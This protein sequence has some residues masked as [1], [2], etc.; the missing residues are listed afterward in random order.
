MEQIAWLGTT[1]GLYETH[2]YNCQDTIWDADNELPSADIKSIAR[3]SQN[4]LWAGTVGG[5]SKYDGS[6][7]ETFTTANS[8]LPANQVN[9]IYVDSG[10]TLWLAIEGEGLIQFDGTNWTLQEQLFPGKS[11]YKV[12]DMTRDSADALWIAHNGGVI[13]IAG[14]DTTFY[15]GENSGLPEE[16]RML[17]IAV[18]SLN[19]KWFGTSQSGVY[20]YDGADWEEYDAESSDLEDSRVKAITIDQDGFL[21]VGSQSGLNKF[22]GSSWVHYDD[23]DPQAGLPNKNIQALFT[24]ADNN[25]WV[26]TNKGVFV[27]GS[28]A[29]MASFS[30]DNSPCLNVSTTF[31]NQSIGGFY[32]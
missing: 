26:G 19:R 29:I 22:D 2:M 17:S 21:W 25:V 30:L 16:G 18:D 24:D 32:L 1:T 7:W 10:D 6:S 5:L 23:T 9:H 27:F 8:S 20:L 12:N 31:Q 15:K 3:D 4:N 13:S 14:T 11:N 28:N